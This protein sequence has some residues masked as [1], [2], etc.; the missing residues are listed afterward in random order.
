MTLLLEA[1]TNQ[2]LSGAVLPK[3]PNQQLLKQGRRVNSLGLIKECA[4]MHA[5]L[6]REFGHRGL[7]ADRR[8]RLERSAVLLPDFRHLYAL[9]L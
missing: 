1:S 3:H 8:Q 2:V 6:A 9:G 7:L 4:R 5:V